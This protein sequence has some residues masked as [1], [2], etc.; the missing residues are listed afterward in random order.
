M[1]VRLSSRT[2]LPR[3]L[4][5]LTMPQIALHRLSEDEIEILPTRALHAESHELL[6]Y[7]VI[8]AWNREHREAEAEIVD[9]AD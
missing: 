3:F 5:F 4:E 9:D 8:R 6:V 1:R 7:P 2:Q